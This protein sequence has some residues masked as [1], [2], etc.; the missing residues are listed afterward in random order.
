MNQIVTTIST[1]FR[2]FTFS[3]W[4][5]DLVQPVPADQWY[6]MGL[7]VLLL[8]LLFIGA[9]AILFWKKAHTPLRSRLINFFWGN[10]VLGL[11]I[12]FF[13]YER[14]PYLGATGIRALYELGILIWLNNI[15]WYRRTGMSK[16]LTEQAV[17]ARKAKYLPKAKIQSHM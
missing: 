1:G 6:F 4:A 16:E 14:I 15:I 10:L 11:V 3:A 17:A 13:R 8:I 7:F 5:K 2:T 12:F 9:L